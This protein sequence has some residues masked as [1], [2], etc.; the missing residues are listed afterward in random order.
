VCV[1]PPGGSPVSLIETY[2]I[3]ADRW[4]SHPLIEDATPRAYHGVATLNKLI[5]I[6]GGFD[7]AQYYNN[8]KSFWLETTLFFF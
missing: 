5:Y 3:R 2:D 7:G 6:I 4:F 8:V 1:Q